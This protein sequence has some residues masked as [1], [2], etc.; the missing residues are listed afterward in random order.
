MMKFFDVLMSG[1]ALDCDLIIGGYEMPASFVWNED[2]T[3]SEYCKEEFG[4]LLDSEVTLIENGNIKIFCSE[5]ELGV[6]FVYSAAG[7]ISNSEYEKLF[8]CDP[9]E[10]LLQLI[11]SIDENIDEIELS[12][13]EENKKN[14]DDPYY[15][16]RISISEDKSAYGRFNIYLD[17]D[18]NKW[19][20]DSGD[21]LHGHQVKLKDDEINYYVFGEFIGMLRRNLQQLKDNK[22]SL[23]NEARWVG[24]IEQT[25]TEKN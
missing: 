3:I 16:I 20:G 9:K 6:R 14:A 7:Y 24:S 11:K 8:E 10:T 4:K 5:K 2:S 23:L 1:K 17:K 25:N 13:I 19:R 15:L 18:G 12:T 21:F 22:Q